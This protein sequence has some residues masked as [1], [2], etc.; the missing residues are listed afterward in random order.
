MIPV[1]QFSDKIEVSDTSIICENILSNYIKFADESV[2]PDTNLYAL[3]KS[4]ITQTD[5][6]LNISAFLNHS[7]YLNF[8]EE[9]LFSPDIIIFDWDVGKQDKEPGEYLKTILE[10]T[11]CLIAIYSGCDKLDEINAILQSEEFN[12]YRS[13]VFT[14][15]KAEENSSQ[16][17]IDK[18]KLHLQDFP[19]DYGKKFRHSVNAAINTTF[20]K[21]G[22]LS[23][24]Q[25]AKLFG[26]LENDKYKI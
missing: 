8:I 22:N 3:I 14:I 25:F 5:L 23:F 26:E 6:D 10:R 7:F 16:I 11:Y 24:K 20:V 18:I 15:G 17:V 21:I 2:W 13:R 19:F 4:L 9:D 1:Q 12:S